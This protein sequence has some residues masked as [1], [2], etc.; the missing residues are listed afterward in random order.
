MGCSPSVPQD[1]VAS[2]SVTNVRPAQNRQQQQQQR[3]PSSTR[4]VVG[5]TVPP[6]PREILSL[7]P[8]EPSSKRVIKE[9]SR[10]L[11][12]PIKGITIIPRP[13]NPRHF[14]I[15]VDGPSGT[16][17][18]G[19]VFKLEMFLPL[20]YPMI[21][22]MAHFLTRI[23]HPNIDR[24]GRICLDILKD[25]WSPALQIDKVCLS[26]QLLMQ[27]PNP[28][29]PLDPRIAKHWKEDTAGAEATAKEWTQLWASGR[30]V[31]QLDD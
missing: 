15:A 31:V 8:S 9:T 16:C 14:D 29:D 22:P 12:N 11:Q 1:N 5:Y 27:V 4:S 19:G 3:A 18:E 30:G 20:E 13:E 10:I 6:R 26:I 21:P 28:D 23:Y 24:V 17:F 25:K 7:D 2:S